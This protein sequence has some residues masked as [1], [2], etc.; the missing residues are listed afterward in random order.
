MNESYE[1]TSGPP[2]LGK[3]GPHSLPTGG[4]ERAPVKPDVHW[5][6]PPVGTG[7]GA[8]SH[9][10]LPAPSA[11]CQRL[12]GAEGRSQKGSGLPESSDR[13][14]LPEWPGLTPQVPCHPQSPVSA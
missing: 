8:H 10:R 7:V 5:S 3:E 2:P 4:S 12:K 13:P 1:W 6:L 11:L 14:P 9:T